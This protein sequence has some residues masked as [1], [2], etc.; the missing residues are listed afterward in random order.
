MTLAAHDKATDGSVDEEDASALDRSVDEERA[1]DALDDEEALAADREDTTTSYVHSPQHAARLLAYL[2]VFGLL[3][4]SARLLEQTYEGVRRDLVEGIRDFP[5]TL[6]PLIEGYVIAAAVL[7]VGLAVAV[8]VNKRLPRFAVVVG[9]ASVA[10]FGLGLL[11]FRMFVDDPRVASNAGFIVA[12]TAAGVAALTVMSDEMSTG[13]LRLCRVALL[14]ASI[15]VC[16]WTRASVSSELLAIVGGAVV[17]AGVGLVGGSPSRA[18]TA[19]A[20]SR[21]LA[22]AGMRTDEV[23]PSS[24]DARASVPWLVRTATGSDLFVKTQT[25]EE[26]SADLLYRAWRALRLRKPG[27]ER[28]ESSLRRAVEHEAFVATRANTV[29]VRTPKLVSLGRI[30]GNGV[31]AA[32]EAIDGRTFEEVGADLS[33]PSLRSAWSMMQ[34]MHRTGIAHRDLRAA[35]LLV[36]GNDDVWIVDFGVAELAASDHQMQIDMVELLASTAAVVGIDRA[37]D[38]AID[39]L[40]RDMIAEALPLLQPAALC[41]ATR[42]AIGKSDLQDLRR[43]LIDKAHV[44]EPDKPHLERIRVKTVLTIVALGIALW[45][46]L[47]QVVRS[48]DLWSRVTHAQLGW[49]GVALVASVVTY[50]ATAIALMGACPTGVPFFSTLQAQ[51]A[52]SF[53]NRI[54]PGNVGGMALNVR[55]LTSE[56]TSTGTAMASVGLS[57]LAG[58]IAHGV[59]M[60][61]AVAWAGSAGFDGFAMPEPRTLAITL[62][63]LLAVIGIGYAI[64]QTRRFLKGRGRA[65]AKQAVADM[66]EVARQPVKLAMLFGGSALVTIANTLALYAGVRA[67]GVDP[68]LATVSV[69]YLAGSAVGSA[70]PTPSGLGALEAAVVAG[71]TA[72]GTPESAAVAGVLVFRLATFW[73]PILP[74]WLCFVALQRADKI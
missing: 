2:L 15:V 50:V 34:A 7:I 66:A 58:G 45:V 33:A 51:V 67:F 16:A 20:V 53:T 71:L 28:P 27:D 73:I 35:N 43:T 32:Y 74:G 70:A 31:F 41:S 40:G 56:G 25:S 22:R 59:L 3:A 69:V 46:L 5:H 60:V 49:V 36:D 48:G 72:T 24:A 44:P 8:A 42:K 52:S 57:S 64:P 68:S 62:G 55:Y 65:Q 17:G 1:D 12:A 38:A 13:L 21:A 26:R 14:P 61:F 19:A 29:G 18:P 54:T 37:V 11:G 47:P 9:A 23:A 6:A 30:G 63:I 39:T 10:A 4:L